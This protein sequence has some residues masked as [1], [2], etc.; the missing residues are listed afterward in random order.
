MQ[1]RGLGRQWVG[2]D[3]SPTAID[4]VKE[5]IKQEGGLLAEINHEIK[6]PLRT[7]LGAE[8][9]STDKKQYKKVLFGQQSGY[10]RGCQNSYDIKLM[11]LD[12]IIPGAKGGTYH[13]ENLQLLCSHCNRKKKDRKQAD[14]LRELSELRG[15]NLSLRSYFGLE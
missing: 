13:K 4:L 15:Q 5:R 14:F 6:L 7:D 1:P 8:L 2:I 9:T 3:I 10:C 11:E 12:R